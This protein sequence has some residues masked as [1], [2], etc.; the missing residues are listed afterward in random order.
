[1][2]LGHCVSSFETQ[3]P[4]SICFLWTTCVGKAIFAV[5]QAHIHFIDIIY[6][7]KI[8][9]SYYFNPES[10]DSLGDKL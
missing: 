8:P 5:S 9:G 10:H 1:M 2:D 3:C 4:K 6:L 7:R